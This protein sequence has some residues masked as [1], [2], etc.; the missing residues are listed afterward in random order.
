MKLLLIVYSGSAS[1]LVP[2]LL[3][4][5]RVGGYTRLTPAHG[6]GETGRREGSRAWPGGADVYFSIVPADR[7]AELTGLLRAEAGRLEEGERLHVAVLP[8]EEFF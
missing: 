3:E 6:A 7:V 1:R 5:Q 8:T 4:A 2:E